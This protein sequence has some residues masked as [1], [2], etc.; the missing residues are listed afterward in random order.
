MIARLTGAALRGLLVALLVATPSL[1]LPTVPADTAQVVAFVAIACAILTTIEYG[2]SCP[3]LFEF[4][5]AAP[6]NRIRYSA[7][8]LV[9]TLISLVVRHHDAPTGFSALVT[10]IGYV[11]GG[12]FDFPYSPLRL[13][14]SR[15]DTTEAQQVFEAI[16]AAMGVA[17]LVYG[18]FLALFF[19]EIRRGRWPRAGS[20][21]VWI[22]LP[23]FDP[24][25]GGDVVS[26]LDRDGKFNILVGL[27]LPLLVPLVLGADGGVI[28]GLAQSEPQA[29]VWTVTIWIGMPFSLFMR[30]LAM[31]R[32]AAMIETRRS[33]STPPQA[34]LVPL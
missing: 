6:F 27:A 7:T 28:G 19:A 13:A 18:G 9:V 1:V 25:R 20:F 22:N 34:G 16:R 3:C 23:T 29:M 24:T 15:P 30:G 33:D 8:L 5:E 14:L 4:R 21:N 32:I 12:L 31:Q 26:R 17:T 2:S 11:V 10:S